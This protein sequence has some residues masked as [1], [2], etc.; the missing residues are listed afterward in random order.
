MNRHFTKE[1][2]PNARKDIPS[3][4]FLNLRAQKQYQFSPIKIA[5]SK[6]IKKGRGQINDITLYSWE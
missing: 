1:T 4:S 2:W 6:M 5:K 3:C